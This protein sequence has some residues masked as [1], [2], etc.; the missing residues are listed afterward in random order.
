MLVS[1]PRRVVSCQR[2]SDTF[3]PIKEL[4]N[5]P[6]ADYPEADNLP[7]P[8]TIAD[9]DHPVPVGTSSGDSAITN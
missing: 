2:R 4:Y 7:G 3:A 1:T 5:Y 6:D 8:R 9:G